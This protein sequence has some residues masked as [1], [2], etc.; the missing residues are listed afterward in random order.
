MER[1]PQIEE[2]P[3]DGSRPPRGMA[4]PK[5]RRFDMF[6]S[7]TRDILEERTIAELTLEALDEELSRRL[8]QKLVTVQ[9]MVDELGRDETNRLLVVLI[10]IE[11][12]HGVGEAAR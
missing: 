12:N 8:A 10:G 3:G 7:K 9:G 1:L 2:G 6:D 5:L 11:K 4:E